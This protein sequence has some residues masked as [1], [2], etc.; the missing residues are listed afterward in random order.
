MRL[1]VKVGS[2]EYYARLNEAAKAL[3]RLLW[4]RLQAGHFADDDEALA[5]QDAYRAAVKADRLQEGKLA[6]RPMD[7]EDRDAQGRL[8]VD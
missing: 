4:M 5:C 1:E 7:L 3:K 2:E 6:Q 8:D